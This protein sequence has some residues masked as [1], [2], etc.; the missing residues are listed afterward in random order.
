MRAQT[1][2]LYLISI[3]CVFFSYTLCAIE[4]WNAA[5]TFIWFDV[6]PSEIPFLKFYLHKISNENTKTATCLLWQLRVIVILLVGLCSSV[7]FCSLTI[8]SYGAHSP[9]YFLCF[10]VYIIRLY[11]SHSL[12]IDFNVESTNAFAL[13]FIDVNSSSQ[14]NIVVDSVNTCLCFTQSCT[15]NCLKSY[16]VISI[17]L[18]AIVLFCFNVACADSSLFQTYRNY[19]LYLPY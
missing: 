19:K 13:D 10:Q 5:L 11:L 17:A 2:V 16:K 18:D 1:F 15:S 9:N 6:Q 12:A 4:M 8:F 3:W 7:R 14:E